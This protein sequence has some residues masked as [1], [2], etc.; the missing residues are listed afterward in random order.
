VA[1]E[2]V[3]KKQYI[4]YTGFFI[5]FFVTLELSH[6]IMSFS[7]NIKKSFIKALFQNIIIIRNDTS[8]IKAHLLQLSRN[9]V[10]YV[11]LRHKQYPSL[12]HFAASLLLHTIILKPV[13]LLQQGYLL[14]SIWRFHSGRAGV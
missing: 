2:S 11:L 10:A 8:I 7:K 5:D 12:K 13:Y 1:Y 4:L 3:C 6:D 14:H 9:S